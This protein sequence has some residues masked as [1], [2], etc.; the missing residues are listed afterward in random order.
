MLKNGLYEIMLYKMDI[1][2]A[3]IGVTTEH[4]KTWLQE[5]S[6][7]AF[8]LWIIHS[9]EPNRNPDGTIK[10]SFQKIAKTL[11]KELAKSYSRIKI[12][13]KVKVPIVG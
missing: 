8:T 10:H 7:N 9:K 5:E 4:V 2:I 13:Y 1:F 11:G 12:K 6:R 3:P